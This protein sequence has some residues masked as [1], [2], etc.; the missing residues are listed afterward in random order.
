M[1]NCNT[2]LRILAI[3]SIFFSQGCITE[4]KLLELKK[5]W[6]KEIYEDSTGIVSTHP[7][8]PFKYGYALKREELNDFNEL[9]SKYDIKNGETVASVGAASGWIEGI[10]STMTDSVEYYIQDIDTSYLNE[11]QLNNVVKHY[12]SLRNSPQTNKFYFIIGEE[13]LTNL[14]ENRFDK[15]IL[16]NSFHEIR[17]KGFAHKI[18]KDLKSKLK[19]NGRIII[20]DETSNDF[21]TIKHE[22]CLIK[23]EKVDQTIKLLSNHGFY[24]VNMSEPRNSFLNC[25]TFSM[26]SEESKKFELKRKQIK[27]IEIQLNKINLINISKNYKYTES[28]VNRI[29]PKINDLK[30]V[31]NSIDMYL[32]RIA[33]KLIDRYQ[34]YRAIN[35]LLANEILFPEKIENYELLGFIYFQQKN[36][37]LSK[38]YFNKV[39]SQD[40]NNNYAKEMIENINK[41]A[42]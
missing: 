31:Y 9:L 27:E 35:V 41:N 14:P 15:I 29:K 5:N 19:P 38:K 1:N 16:N 40:S 37:T 18:L 39:L 20:D 23:A 24:L 26:K 6:D 34:Y 3:T 7:S 30:Q 32:I 12:S 36:Y 8:R 21:I 10:F 17:K 28:L 42:Q 25:L 4:K 2:A 22:G 13:H 11:F 33:N